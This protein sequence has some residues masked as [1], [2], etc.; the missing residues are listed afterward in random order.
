MCYII[1]QPNNLFPMEYNMWHLNR[2]WRQVKRRSWLSFLLYSQVSFFLTWS[3]TILR[4][5]QKRIFQRTLSNFMTSQITSATLTF[6]SHIMIKMNRYSWNVICAIFW[7]ESIVYYHIAHNLN[8]S[9]NRN[10][11]RLIHYR[12]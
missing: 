5:R 1:Q 3:N 7:R 10:D 6:Y 9:E 2:Y 11:L 12:F 8:I 4:K